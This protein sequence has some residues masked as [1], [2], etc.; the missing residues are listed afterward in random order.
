MHNE[1]TRN[2][3]EELVCDC[4]G[5]PW[6]CRTSGWYCGNCGQWQCTITGR[7]SVRDSEPFHNLK[8]VARTFFGKHGAHQWSGICLAEDP[9]IT[10]NLGEADIAYMVAVRNYLSTSNTRDS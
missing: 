1:V 4:P 3:S 10:Y 7:V 8:S 9:V 5:S 6:V 2:D